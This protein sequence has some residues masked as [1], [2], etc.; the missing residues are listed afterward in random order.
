MYIKAI[1]SFTAISEAANFPIAVNFL[2]TVPVRVVVLLQDDI[3]RRPHCNREGGIV[4]I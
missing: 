2:A 3:R 1:H 4:G